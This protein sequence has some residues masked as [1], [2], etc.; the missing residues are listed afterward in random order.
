MGQKSIGDDDN[1]FRW[2]I[3][4]DPIRPPRFFR[5]GGT[6][7]VT[8]KGECIEEQENGTA[9]IYED[10]FEAVWNKTLKEW[11]P[12]LRGPLDFSRYEYLGKDLEREYDMFVCMHR[13]HRSN[14]YK[15]ELIYRGKR[16][17]IASTFK[18]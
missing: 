16:M 17:R 11:T 12:P 9:D 10:H 14:D 8:P 4:S 3:A 18:M 5:I 1:T 6:T 15:E 2:W 7:I 13:D